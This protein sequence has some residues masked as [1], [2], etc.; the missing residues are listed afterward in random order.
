MLR[1]ST[2]AVSQCRARAALATIALSSVLIGCGPS[3][4]ERFDSGRKDGYAAGY[5]TACDIRATLIA[6]TW[7]D[8]QYSRGYAIGH[9]EGIAA[10]EAD[11]H[12]GTV[13]D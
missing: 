7:D 10:C 6:G 2:V 5:N 9:S 12:S 1:E 8:D 13:G 4:S 11:R 3:K